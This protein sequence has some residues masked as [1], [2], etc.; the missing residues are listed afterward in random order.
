MVEGGH[1][2]RTSPLIFHPQTQDEKDLS[3]GMLD[4]LGRYR[5]TLDESR[6]VIFDRFQL[7]D[8][9]IKVVGLAASGRA[10]ESRG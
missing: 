1:P 4:I 9:A 2:G 3:R 8:S 6:R 5:H 10:V 7:I